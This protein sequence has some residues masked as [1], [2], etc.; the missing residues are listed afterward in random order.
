M[1]INSLLNFFI[2]FDVSP[3]N[4]FIDIFL[5]DS[6]FDDIKSIVA[7]ASS[8]SILPFKN[9]LLVN[10]PGSASLAPFSK[11]TSNTLLVVAIPPWQFISTTSSHVNVLGAF[12]METKTSSIFSSLFLINP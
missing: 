4:V 11:S 7:S 2:R 12:I 3:V 9:A 6:A 1:A 5:A 10:S 8:K